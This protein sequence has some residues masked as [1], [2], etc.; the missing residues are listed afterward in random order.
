MQVFA[1]ILICHTVSAANY[2][3]YMLIS[4]VT[5]LDYKQTQ[6]KVEIKLLS[7]W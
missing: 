7:L 3:G 1:K 6:T 4:D 2:E 5:A